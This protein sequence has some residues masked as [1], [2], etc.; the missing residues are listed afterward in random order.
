MRCEK[1]LLKQWKADLQAIQEEKRREE[2]RR[3][4]KRL[5]KKKKKKAKKKN[6]NKKYTI[7]GNTAD[8]MDGKNTYRKEN[9][10]WK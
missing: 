9:G 5:K 6:K 8:F 3:E 4:E 7:P 2:K 10:V 1:D